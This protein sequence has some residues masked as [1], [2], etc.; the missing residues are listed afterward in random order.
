MLT[1]A[2]GKVSFNPLCQTESVIYYFV[3]NFSYFKNTEAIFN[4]F[5][6]GATTATSDVR[7]K[8]TGLNKQNLS[9]S[10]RL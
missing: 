6:R 5:V 8:Q 1:I 3:A 10:K 7:V 9:F 4:D 2:E